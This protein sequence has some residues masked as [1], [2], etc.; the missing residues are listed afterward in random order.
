MRNLIVALGVGGILIA[1]GV[2]WDIAFQA[3]F[4]P[5]GPDTRSVFF[6]GYDPRQVVVQF[7]APQNAGQ[8]GSDV[9][10][11]RFLYHHDV[12]H[13]RDF[14]WCFRP[15][16]HRYVP[17]IYAMLDDVKQTL[18]RSGAR[19]TG[20]QMDRDGRF[21]VLYRAGRSSGRIRLDPPKPGGNPPNLDVLNLHIDERW[22]V[23]KS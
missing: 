7:V 23:S 18:T 6:L 15:T 11:S 9:A 3:D 1:A 16:H 2:T 12:R 4:V 14:T 8:G 19:I 17:L 10:G 22:L 13:S 21:T 20:E 5:C